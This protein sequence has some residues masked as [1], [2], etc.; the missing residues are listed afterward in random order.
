MHN[1][2]LLLVFIFCVFLSCGENND[3]FEWK[4]MEVKASAY[5]SVA[6]Q[7]D[8][9]PSLAAWGD[10]LVPGQ[11][12]I[13]ISRDLIALGIDHNTQVKIEG[14]NGTYLVKDK[15]N[16]RYTKKIDIFMGKDVARAKEWGIKKLTIQYRVK[17]AKDQ[18]KQ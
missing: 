16:A 17:K 18:K 2:A 1:K 7:T 10:T 14:L 3:G 9:K 15:M 6:S 8:G 4:T 11:K 5:N 12:V 13:A